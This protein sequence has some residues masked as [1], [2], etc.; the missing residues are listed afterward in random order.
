MPGPIVLSLFAAA[1]LACTAYWTRHDRIWLRWT[2]R[3]ALAGV[4]L[5]LLL[6]ADAIAQISDWV[7]SLLPGFKES[8]PRQAGSGAGHVVMFTVIGFLFGRL[9]P[10]IGWPSLAV[11][12]TALVVLTEAL[13]H[14]SPGRHPSLLD[15]GFNTTGV[16]LGL[17]LLAAARA[18]G[19]A[20]EP[21]TLPSPHASD[22][23]L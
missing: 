21:A 16:I 9:R 1:V 17:G 20:P 5:A 10:V 18:L 19:V 2:T 3:L 13:Q 23:S 12:L 4:L 8:D 15:V 11:F 7:W 14:L 22:R 6:P